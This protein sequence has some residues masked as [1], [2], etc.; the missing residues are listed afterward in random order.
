MLITVND[1]PPQKCQFR[2]ICYVFTILLS[3]S[4]DYSRYSFGSCKVSLD[5]NF[6]RYQLRTLKPSISEHIALTFTVAGTWG[7]SILVTECLLFEVL[8]RAMIHV[9]ISV[10]N[11]VYLPIL[12]K[13][14]YV[15]TKDKQINTYSIM[16]LVASRFRTMVALPSFPGIG[17]TREKHDISL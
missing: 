12:E 3:C 4:T 8:I 15:V 9:S 14:E 2:N 1:P 11:A 5:L 10:A 17:L 16:S 13:D 6:Y 7:R